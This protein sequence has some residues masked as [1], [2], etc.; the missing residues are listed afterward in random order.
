MGKELVQG[1]EKTPQRSLFKALGFSDDELSKPLIAVI[2]AK[3]E[4]VPGH[5]HLDRITDAVKAG[6]Y[7]AGGTPIVIPSIGV[8]DGIAMGH[9]GMRYSL[10]SRE[11]IAD[12]VESMLIGHAFDGAV[13]VPNCDKIVP[14]MI[15]G[16]A[17]V[18]IPSIVISGGAM[19]SGY[20]KG[21]KTSLSSCFEAVGKVQAGTMSVDELKELENCACP[22][23]GSCC[24][25]YTANSLNCLSEALGIALPGNGTILAT[26]SERIRLAKKAGSSIMKLVSNDIRPRMI[27]TEE[28]FTNA[29][30]VDM[31]IG[32]STNTILHLFAIANECG[33]K[34]DLSLVQKVSDR[35]P[36][37]CKLSPATENDMQDLGRA[38]GIMAIMNQLAQKNLIN[39]D[40]L[41]VLN[42]SIKSSY[43]NA[44]IINPDIIHPIDNPIAP[45]GGIAVLKGNFCE[46]GAVVKRSAVAPEMMTFTGVAKV[47]DCEEDCVSAIMS[48]KIKKGNVVIIRYEGPKGGPGMR[49]MLSPTSA[50]VGM[51]LDKDVALIT[52]GRFSGATRGAAIG[53]VSPEASVGGKIAL[54]NDGDKITIDIPNG[55]LNVDIK[56]KELQARTKKWKPKDRNLN[57]WLLRYSYLVT[58]ADKGA[59]LKTKF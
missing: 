23:C 35:T 58:S 37:L 50:L 4:I 43:K 39:S 47:F 45:T 44:E 41:T 1:I 30:A 40:A 54:I 53:H 52:D 33:I 16:A 7:S 20:F 32:A 36:N 42:K 6:V 10:P 28:A 48:G 46:D 26:S 8:C 13:L 22:G 24:G 55:K 51:G 59:V 56:A 2:S 38:G 18:N 19:E 5:M 17:R 11:L 49:E 3:S 34:L 9:D 25:M 57:G 12:S 15:M 21:N 14:G 27:L 29:L 31:A